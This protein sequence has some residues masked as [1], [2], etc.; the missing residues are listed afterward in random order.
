M[1]AV[2]TK[3][4]PVSEREKLPAAY[5]AVLVWN[6]RRS[7]IEVAWMHYIDGEYTWN[8]NKPS[9]IS[10]WMPLPLPPEASDE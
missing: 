1:G 2:M 10:H 3:W 5:I 9:D 7:H 8:T 4:I 6:R